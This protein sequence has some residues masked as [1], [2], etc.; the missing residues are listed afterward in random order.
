MSIQGIR[1]K[2]PPSNPSP[3]EKPSQRLKMDE[4]VDELN[5]EIDKIIVQKLSEDYLGC[6]FI[7]SSFLLTVTADCCEEIDRD[8]LLMPK[9]IKHLKKNPQ[10]GQKLQ[11]AWESRSFKDILLLRA[12]LIYHFLLFQVQENFQ[13][14]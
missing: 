5:Q 2:R 4:E 12:R 13:R 9:C 1:A 14:N 7:P 11:A 3:E 8:F 6:P 10:L